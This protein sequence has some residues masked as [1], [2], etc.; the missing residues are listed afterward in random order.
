[1]KRYISYCNFCVT[2]IDIKDEFPEMI[3]PVE[4]QALSITSRKALL[5]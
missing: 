2:P 5:L 3:I 1:V 4:K